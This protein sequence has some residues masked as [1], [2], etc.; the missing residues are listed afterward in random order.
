MS[1]YIAVIEFDESEQVFGAYFPD[2]PGCTAMGATEQNVV[3]NA[4][5]ALSEWISDVI[6]E[7]QGIPQPRT[8]MQLREAGEL[9]RDHMIAT[10][11]LLRETGKVV[12]ANISMDAG[13]LESIDETAG[14]IGL[15]RSAFLASAA[16]DK[17]KQSG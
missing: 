2:A 16:R 4:I 8:Y 17:I 13:L 11:P 14:R 6:A 1:R 10:L 5:D 15:T 7:G 3:D 9:G 12:R